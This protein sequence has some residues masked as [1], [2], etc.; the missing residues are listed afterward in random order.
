MSYFLL[1]FLSLIICQ[2]DDGASIGD[3]IEM[4]IGETKRDSHTYI[5]PYHSKERLSYSTKNLTIMGILTCVDNE[6][7]YRLLYTICIRSIL[8]REIYYLD[9]S[10]ERNFHKFMHQLSLIKLFHHHNESI[11]DLFVTQIWPSEWCPYYMIQYEPTVTNCSQIGPPS[12]TFVYAVMDMMMTYK[13]YISNEHYC[14]DHNERL[15]WDG[16]QFRCICRRGRTCHNDAR[17]NAY[18]TLLVIM[19]IGLFFL[20]IAMSFYN[21]TTFFM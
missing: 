11:E 9:E 21:T 16:N 19:I 7:L 13:Q 3:I 4:A 17:T 20:L 18:I 2:S 1:L 10:N 5:K 15:I 6:D 8:C 14:N 12:I